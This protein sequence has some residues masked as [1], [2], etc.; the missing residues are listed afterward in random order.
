MQKTDLDM[1]D[2]EIL[3]SR[4]FSPE[5]DNVVLRESL[6]P[7][8]RGE[9]YAQFNLGLVYYRGG[10]HIQKNY[11]EAV[12]WTRRAAEQGF[13]RAQNNLGV[14]YEYGEGVAQDTVEAYKWYT[15]A[16]AQDHEYA[17]I[18]IE[19]LQENM[20]KNQI[21]EAQRLLSEWQPKKEN[22]IHPN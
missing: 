19:R 14:M 9:A 13:S 22:S 3:Y 20:E 4:E 18:S 5:Y 2:K 11:A 16:A 6:S 15:L 12:K 7:A 8:E 21:A 10:L 17:K 1:S